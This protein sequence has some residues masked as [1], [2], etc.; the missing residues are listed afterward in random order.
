[1][2]GEIKSKRG[3]ILSKKSIGKGTVCRAVAVGE[4]AVAEENSRF[5]TDRIRRGQETTLIG[6]PTPNDFDLHRPCWQKVKR[7]DVGRDYGVG[8]GVGAAAVA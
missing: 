5:R 1:M 6:G 8:G 3:N 4:E 7:R 2:A